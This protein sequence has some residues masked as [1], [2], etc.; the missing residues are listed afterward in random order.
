VEELGAMLADTSGDFIDTEKR[1]KAR[2][3]D[4]RNNANIAR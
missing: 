3:T 1:R 4:M 2:S